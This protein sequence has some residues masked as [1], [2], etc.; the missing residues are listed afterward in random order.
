ME[1]RGRNAVTPAGRRF[2]IGEKMAQVGVAPF[3]ADLDPLHALGVVGF[4]DDDVVGDRFA[5]GRD[6]Q[7]ARAAVVF[8]ERSE[9]RLASMTST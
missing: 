2:R 1:G 6:A 9:E 8:V 3:R 7:A 4:L 5:E